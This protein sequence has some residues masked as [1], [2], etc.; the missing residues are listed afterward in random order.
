MIYF[1]LEKGR[2][3]QIDS[4]EANELYSNNVFNY[5][6][7]LEEYENLKNVEI[8]VF[9]LDRDKL[10]PVVKTLLEW[11][12]PPDNSFWLLTIVWIVIFLFILLYFWF[13]YLTKDKEVI[14]QKQNIPIINTI[15][16][17]KWLNLSQNNS[18]NQ[19]V[20]TNTWSLDQNIIETSI[21]QNNDVYYNN[22]LMNLQSK[23]DLETSIL[24][25]QLDN[26]K[27]LCDSKI[28]LL[29][30][31]INYYKEINETWL[32]SSDDLLK[33]KS[34]LLTCETSLKSLKLDESTFIKYLWN[35]TFDVCNK[36]K[37]NSCLE[38]FSNFYKNVK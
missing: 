1:I 28:D 13:S 29:N 6:W 9:H 22:Q 15:E 27:I 37:T 4:I 8:V 11:E 24:K 26:N 34:D 31:Q 10:K 35:Y 33:I 19:I 17:S 7:I 23:Y 21:T 32:K 3:L 20:N 16:T 30:T 25:N 2:L 18:S 38:L 5:S 14:E 36:S 12:Q